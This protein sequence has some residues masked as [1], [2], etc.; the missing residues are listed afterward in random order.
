[1]KNP[2]KNMKFMALSAIVAGIVA[3]INVLFFAEPGNFPRG[4]SIAFAA[5]AVILGIIL[6]IVSGKPDSTDLKE[7]Q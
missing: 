7:N 4:R 6:L 1:M 2:F 5:A 3:L